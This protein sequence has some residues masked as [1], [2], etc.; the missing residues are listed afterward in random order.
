[1]SIAGGSRN[2]N[3]CFPRWRLIKKIKEHPS[4]WSENITQHLPLPDSPNFSLVTAFKAGGI[5]WQVMF[6]LLVLMM[7]QEFF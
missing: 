3:V 6:K 4:P 1:M 7:E 5:N 2:G